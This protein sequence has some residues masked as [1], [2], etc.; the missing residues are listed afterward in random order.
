MTL[1]TFQTHSTFKRWV[2]REDIRSHN[3]NLIQQ[4]RFFDIDSPQRI[5][6]FLTRRG[7]TEESE[8]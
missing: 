7:L 6:K 1:S 5:K 2:E 3:L 4:H 8:E